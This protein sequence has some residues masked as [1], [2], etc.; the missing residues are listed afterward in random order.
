MSFLTLALNL[1]SL[2]SSLVNPD[3][4]DYASAHITLSSGLTLKIAPEHTNPANGR[5]L[6]ILAILGFIATPVSMFIIYQLRGLFQ[7]FARKQLLT[8]E[9][10]KRIRLIGS[11][12][13]VTWVFSLVADVVGRHY[14]INA[15][16]IPGVELTG[17]FVPDYWM[18]FLG[19]IVLVIAEI[20]KMAAETS[21]ESKLTV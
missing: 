4:L 3:F 21:E 20:H 16:T 18:L 8:Q 9:N 14:T 6:L 13:V 2:V 12:T 17:V 19:I 15:V 10:A 5:L 7:A 1:Y 11:A